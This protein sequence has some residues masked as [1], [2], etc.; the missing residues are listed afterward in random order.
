M[1]SS[2]SIFHVFVSPIIQNKKD[3]QGLAS[4]EVYRCNLL[5]GQTQKATSLP[6]FRTL[7]FEPTQ[8]TYKAE[9]FMKAMQNYPA[10]QISQRQNLW[11]SVTLF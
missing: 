9:V 11:M 2:F 8:H 3:A 6:F 1:F 7:K 5:S 10:N 4:D